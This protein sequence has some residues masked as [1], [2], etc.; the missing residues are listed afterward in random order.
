MSGL[1]SDEVLDL[2]CPMHL[3][4]SATGHILHAGP[5][6]RKLFR[7]SAV[8]GARFL[9]LFC[10]KRPRAVICMGDLIGAEDPKL[11]L[12]MRNPVRTSLKGVLVRAPNESDVIVNLGFGIS[13]I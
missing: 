11:H 8:T 1:P 9:E 5:T 3:R 2:L 12:E 6:A 7:D 4:V 10:V 13:I